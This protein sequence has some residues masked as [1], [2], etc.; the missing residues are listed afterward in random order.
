M[1]RQGRENAGFIPESDFSRPAAFSNEEWE[2]LPDDV[3]EFVKEYVGVMQT[4][5]FLARFARNAHLAKQIPSLH[6]F[7]T[8]LEKRQL[9]VQEVGH[10]MYEKL[11]QEQKEFF[12]EGGS[13]GL[14]LFLC[15]V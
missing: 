12:I 14:F 5:L 11:F 9:K 4:R 6:S 15:V 1:E 3:R 2:Q 7:L 8:E 10:G 13:S